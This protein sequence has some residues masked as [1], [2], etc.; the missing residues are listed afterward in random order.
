MKLGLPLA[1]PPC[2][3]RVLFSCM[4]PGP[5]GQLFASRLGVSD[6]RPG[7][8]QTHSEAGFLLLALSC[9]I[10]DPDLINHWTPPRLPSDNGKQCEKPAVI[11]HCLP[12]VPQGPPPPRNTV[13]G[14]SPSQVAGGEP[15]GSPAFSL[16]TVSLIQRFNRLLPV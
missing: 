13:T 1:R 2:N 10:G 5:V 15:C 14:Q 11:T 3:G 16:H 8:A 9:Y 4:T 12:P 7:D 6:S